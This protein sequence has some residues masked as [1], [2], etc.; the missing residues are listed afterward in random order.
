M[1]GV[2]WTCVNIIITQDYS[3]IY[4]FTVVQT[5]PV[6]H[7]F[8]MNRKVVVCFIGFGFVLCFLF[9]IPFYF[10][11]SDFSEI[12]EKKAFVITRAGEH[13]FDGV[14]GK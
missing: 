10:A 4:R 9:A 13:I 2:V 6:Y 11:I 7:E 5:N 1:L 12:P 14:P 3:L 8:L